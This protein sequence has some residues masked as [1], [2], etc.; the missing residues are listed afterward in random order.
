MDSFWDM[1][2]RIMRGLGDR[3]VSGLTEF[4]FDTDNPEETILTFHT[5]DNGKMVL[6]VFSKEQWSLIEDMSKF[7]GKPTE[8]IVKELDPS[9]PNIYVLDPEDLD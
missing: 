2:K 9:G 8:D 7:V 5:N 6:S 3:D 4:S 1:V